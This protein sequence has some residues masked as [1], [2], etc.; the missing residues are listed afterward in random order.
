MTSRASLSLM[1]RQERGRGMQADYAIIGGGIVGLSV[2]WGLQRRGLQVVVLDGDDGDFRA[3]R[4]N[5]GLIWVQGKGAKEPR[6]AAWT[7]GSAA[8]WADFA[9]EL[10]AG[11]GRDLWLR[12]DGG[13]EVFFDEEE[14]AQTVATYEGLKA[15]LGGDYPFEVLGGNALRR[16]EPA[17]GPKAVG[18]ILHAEDG[19][20]SPLLLL[21]ALADDLRR[22][23]GRVLTGK[24]VVAV[25][26][27]DQFRVTCADGTRLDAGK[28]VL[29]AGLGAAT[30]GP[31]LG[32]QA[33][34]RPQRG[35]ILITEKLPK[36]LNRPTVDLR[37]VEEGGFQIGATNEEV[38][39]DDSVTQPAMARLAARAVDTVPALAR[40]QLVRSWAALRVMT[41]D[42][43]PIYQ[44]SA[45]MPG[46]FLVTCHSG[47]TLAAAHALRLPDWLEARAGAP[48]LSAFSEARFSP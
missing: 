42:G 3:S 7:R 9:A 31:M 40:A 8:L 34:V 45:T 16:E 23:G 21:R 35:Q 28:V 25:D 38:G 4:G 17:I 24:K 18:A 19:H 41:P 39:F 1:G 5:F 20:T 10:S 37:Q 43:L 44:R 36:L 11:S 27:L 2:A 13:Y 46:A 15:K 33:P 29:A 26:R 47:I 48:D 6:Y 12:Q 32:F 22:L 14:M 30:L